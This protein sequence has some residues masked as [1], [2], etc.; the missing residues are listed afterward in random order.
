M[1]L[2][3]GGLRIKRLETLSLIPTDLIG[4]T[5]R[6]WAGK[7]GAGTPRPER[8]SPSPN[9]RAGSGPT[10]APVERIPIVGPDSK[11]NVQNVTKKLLKP[12][13]PAL[14]FRR[15]FSPEED[16]INHIE[17]PVWKSWHPSDPSACDDSA[18]PTSGTFRFTRGRE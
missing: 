3:E 15:W 13:L 11:E 9:M 14:G 4:W 6:V 1:Y 17:N 8:S 16:V 7:P 10:K 12:S 2:D 18:D 5:R